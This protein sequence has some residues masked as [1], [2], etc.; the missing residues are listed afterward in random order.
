MSTTHSRATATKPAKKLPFPWVK[1]PPVNPRW[2]N[3]SYDH[4]EP[5][6]WSLND[7]PHSKTRI[8]RDALHRLIP[9]RKRAF[10]CGLQLFNYH[11]TTIKSTRSAFRRWEQS[12]NIQRFQVKFTA[13]GDPIP[14]E[15]ERAAVIYPLVDQYVTSSGDL[16]QRPSPG[17]GCFGVTFWRAMDM[18]CGTCP[19]REACDAVVSYRLVFG[20]REVFQAAL[21]DKEASE[22][23][24]DRAAPK[25]KSQGYQRE[26]EDFNIRKLRALYT[27]IW[28]LSDLTLPKRQRDAR[29]ASVRQT[30]KTVRAA[31]A[32][33]LD[34]DQQAYDK[35]CRSLLKVAVDNG[36]VTTLH[37][38]LDEFFG[39]N[40]ADHRW[41]KRR[42]QSHIIALVALADQAARETDK[43]GRLWRRWRS[44]KYIHEMTVFAQQE[45]KALGSHCVT[46][47]EVNYNQVHRHLN[48]LLEIK[49]SGGCLPNCI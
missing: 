20:G 49:A 10:R 48:T 18:K 37:N 7:V 30:A 21:K 1:R 15:K 24:Y 39:N 22:R 9:E 19:I 14:L 26:L 5:T 41:R 4:P 42:S 29:R 47:D 6:Y 33:T 44:K 8:L 34:A 16:K 27:G 43:K 38:A 36:G 3:P 32:A 12:A 13:N 2:S 35:V 31:K 28:Y 23:C 25:G 11:G 40:A 46:A 45:L 17:Y